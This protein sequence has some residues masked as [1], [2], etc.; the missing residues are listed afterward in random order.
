MRRA[1]RTRQRKWSEAAATTAMARGVPDPSVISKS[2]FA[3]RLGISQKE[4][5]GVATLPLASTD[6]AFALP[7]AK[8]TSP[9]VMGPGRAMGF[10]RDQDGGRVCLRDEREAE[11]RRLPCCNPTAAI[12]E[13]SIRVS[14]ELNGR[15]RRPQ[16]PRCQRRARRSPP[17]RVGWDALP[18]RG[19]TMWQIRPSCCA[20]RGCA[21]SRRG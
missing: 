11:Q 7:S 8:S 10:T 3:H 20:P 1:R 5:Q 12:A 4:P 18:T 16:R 13:V 17:T 14:G 9:S 21:P 19:R 2:V 6:H 15:P